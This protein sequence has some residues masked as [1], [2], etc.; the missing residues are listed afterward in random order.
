MVD[1]GGLGEKINPS[2]WISYTL[3]NTLTKQFG[4]VVLESVHVNQSKLPTLDAL[5]TLCQETIVDTIVF[6]KPQKIDS[7]SQKYIK[8]IINEKSI[9]KT[10]YKNKKSL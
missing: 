1:N 10:I 2:S 5:H 7:R 6:L 9:I 3:M 4:T 8:A